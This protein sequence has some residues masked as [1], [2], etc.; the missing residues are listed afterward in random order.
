MR[1]NSLAGVAIIHMPSGEND[2]DWR[3]VRRE[4][5]EVE[6]SKFRLLRAVDRKKRVRL[7]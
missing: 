5:V 4:A 3:C 6:M 7:P 2:T 1:F